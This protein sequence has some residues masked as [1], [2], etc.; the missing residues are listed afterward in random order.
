MEPDADFIAAIADAW[1]RSDASESAYERGQILEEIVR[2]VFGALPGFLHWRSRHVTNNGDAEFDV[3]FHNDI[4]ESLFPSA[5]PA[6]VVECKNTAG[7]IGSGDVRNF[8]AKM[9]DVQ[10]SWA[11]LVAANGIT[12]SGER[13]SAAHAVI[14]QARL[15][16]INV[17]VEV[18]LT[19][20][21][22]DGVDNLNAAAALTELLI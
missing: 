1:A 2:F 9:E 21:L 6:M 17:L 5:E 20:S 8:V 10:L 11:F 22:N 3:C 15:R 12:G 19:C 18:A 7:A 14:Q 13:N 4:R 16:K